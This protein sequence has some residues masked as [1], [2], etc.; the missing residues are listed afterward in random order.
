MTVNLEKFLFG[1]LGTRLFPKKTDSDTLLKLWKKFQNL[2]SEE[3][4]SIDDLVF[5]IRQP[6]K[7]V[8]Y[9]TE[10]LKVHTAHILKPYLLSPPLLSFPEMDYDEE[11][12]K[13]WSSVESDVVASYT[14]PEY[15]Q[16]I[17]IE[18]ALQDEPSD[19]KNVKSQ[20]TIAKPK[21]RVQKI[22]TSD[23]F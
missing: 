13:F 9:T 19:Y 12:R 2:E 5:S 16:S 15:M 18:H 14:I 1:L 4:E 20:S 8:K 22:K 17:K 11:E 6:H 7:S 23:W 21:G 10:E 3:V